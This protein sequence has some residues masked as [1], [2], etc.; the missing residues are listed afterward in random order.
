[1]HWVR[2]G[3]R[4]QCVDP[5]HSVEQLFNGHQRRDDPNFVRRVVRYAIPR[6][7]VR[8]RRGGVLTAALRG[9]LARIEEAEELVN[10]YRSA[11]VLV[12]LLEEASEVGVGEVG[13]GEL[14][15]ATDQALELLVV[16]LAAMVGVLLVEERLPVLTRR[17]VAGGGPP[18]TDKLDSLVSQVVDGLDGV[19]IRGCLVLFVLSVWV[20]EGRQL[21][22]RDVTARGGRRGRTAAAPGGLVEGTVGVLAP[23]EEG[24]EV[25]DLTV[26]D[27]TWSQLENATKN[28]AQFTG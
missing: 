1:M 25:V 4:S 12:K 24:E 28:P 10:G 11:V 8:A 21:V 13:G 20:E 5:H 7:C 18:V 17:S 3:G 26:R 15:H 27:L 9:R 22:D 6:P 14:E 2:C 23:G 19:C 16:Q